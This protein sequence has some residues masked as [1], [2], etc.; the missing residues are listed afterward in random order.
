MPELPEVET[1]VEQLKKRIVDKTI[2][3][4]DIFDKIV[5]PKIKNILPLKVLNV[6]RR[7]K[8]IVF[9]LEKEHYFF[10]HL[11]MTGHFHYLP[12][13]KSN[14]SPSQLQSRQELAECEKFMTAKFHFNDG[15]FLIHNDIRKFGFIKLFNKKQLDEELNKLGPEPLA[16]NFTL[17]TLKELLS[18]NGKANL[19]VTLMDQN[20]ISGI[21]NIYA[22]EVLYHAGISPLRK[23]NS[24]NPTETKLLYEKIKEILSLAIKHHGTT[25]ENY[26]HIEGS[27]G[28]QKYLAVYQQEHCP[29]KHLLKKITLG[30]RGTSYCPICQK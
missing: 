24:L 8:T 21:G 2:I 13:L 11:R 17:E 26:V 23:I 16:K 22:Q 25:V 6:Y 30:G 18:S 28:F 9:E 19:K 14:S 15:S 3:K 7:A 20:F 27:G 10:V 29:K 1:L 12:L 5:D 4:V